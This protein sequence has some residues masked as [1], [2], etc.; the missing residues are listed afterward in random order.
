MPR[1]D[2]EQI[3]AKKV[4]GPET[5]SDPTKT[6]HSFIIPQRLTAE[7]S[8][9]SKRT[10]N[11]L[12]AFVSQW[13]VWVIHDFMRLARLHVISRD[14]PFSAADFDIN[15]PVRTFSFFHPM[16]SNDGLHPRLGQHC[17]LNSRG[18]LIG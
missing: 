7:G 17:G 5:N 8:S 9:K 15:L 18:D 13:W 6:M 16:H 11:I 10:I 1:H 3:I 14:I 2:Y 4:H 12:A